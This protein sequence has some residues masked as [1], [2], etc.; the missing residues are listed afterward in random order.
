MLFRPVRS[1]RVARMDRMNPFIECDTPGKILMPLKG[2][3]YA[4]VLTVGDI[5]KALLGVKYML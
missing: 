1:K 2:R 5:G 3:I 4:S